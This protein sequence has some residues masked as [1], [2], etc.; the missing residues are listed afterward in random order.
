MNE[1][2]LLKRVTEAVQERPRLIG[3]ILEICVKRWD[4]YVE[5]VNEQ[6]RVEHTYSLRAALYAG[7]QGRTELL[8]YA[9][10]Y[11]L[12]DAAVFTYPKGTASASCPADHQVLQLLVRSMRVLAMKPE[13]FADSRRELVD[14]LYQQLSG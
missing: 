4:A 3:P 12:L 9:Q 8:N 10:V 2:D 11:Q 13:E 5:Q 7:F 1:E 14:L 6:R